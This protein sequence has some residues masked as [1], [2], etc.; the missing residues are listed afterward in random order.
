M[1]GLTKRALLC[2]LTVLMLSAIAVGC[3]MNGCYK[4]D[5]DSSNSNSQTQCEHVFGAWYVDELPTCTKEG[6]KHKACLNSGCDFV[7]TEPIPADGHTE[8]TD[9]ARQPTCVKKGLTVGSHCSVCGEVITEQEKITKLGHSFGEWYE[10]VPSTETV[11]GELRR[12]CERCD[13]YETAKAPLKGHDY[14]AGEVVKPTC[15]AYG[16]TVYTCE[17]GDSYNFDFTNML[18]HDE[19][20]TV[21]APTCTKEGYTLHVCNACSLTYIS[22]YSLALGHDFGAWVTKTEATC[23][24]D[25]EQTAECSR[26]KIT[27]SQTVKA[28]GHNYVQTLQDENQT[29]VKYECSN[30][31]DVV[32]LENVNE[33]EVLGEEEQLLD[34]KTTFS[35]TVISTENAAYVRENLSVIDAYFEDSEHE[36]NGN[37]KISFK[38]TP[39]ESILNGYVISPETPYENGATYVAKL[40]DGLK[41]NDYGGKRLTFSIERTESNEVVFSDDVIFLKALEQASPGYYPYDLKQTETSE[42]M[43]LTLQKIGDLK[44]GDI[45]LIGDAAN[46]EELYAAPED[47]Y[48][49]KIELIYFNDDSEYVCVLSYP[50]ITEIFSKLNVSNETQINFEDYPEAVEILEKESVNC[51]YQSDDFAEFLLSVDKTVADYASERNM[52]TTPITKTAF[53]DNIM[54]N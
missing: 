5:Y 40:G 24:I 6:S 1:K 36:E 53:K 39:H 19:K 17:C 29:S 54:Q 47:V 37:A 23:L 15:S 33:S 51:L 49:G 46:V 32:L 21:V 26:C 42:F 44:K 3:N 14:I 11:N 43:Q 52:T 8:V 45:L 7:L 30:C 13:E 4:S 34:Q 25:G 38:I 20:L 27:R 22:G 12:D 35:F 9:E 41:F 50:E 2:F 28:V 18:P 16:Y 31:G 10:S 48:F